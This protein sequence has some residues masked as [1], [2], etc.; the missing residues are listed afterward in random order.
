MKKLRPSSIV[1]IIVSFIAVWLVVD[2]IWLADWRAQRAEDR[3]TLNAPTTQSTARG[4]SI[5]ADFTVLRNKNFSETMLARGF[6]Q[7][8]EETE[9][10]SEASGKI[11]EINFVEGTRVK[12]GT[13]LVKINDKDLQAQ[14]ERAIHRQKLAEDKEARQK[15]LLEKDAISLE[16]YET[17]LTELNS[18]K[19]EIERTEI[20]APFDGTVGLRSVSVGEYISPQIAVAKLVNNNPIKMH[21]SISEKYYD[22]VKVNMKV[23]FTVYGDTRIHEA[24]VYAIDPSIDDASRM[25]QMRALTANPDGA[26]FPGPSCNIQFPLNS[27]N[28]AIMVPSEALISEASGHKAF[29]YKNGVA[30]YRDLEI[31]TRTESQVQVTKG[32]RPGD[33]LIVSGILQLRPGGLVKLENEIK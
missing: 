13:L 11:T 8:D 14:H 6:L 12:A 15:V 20:R 26:L 19:A 9:L 1:I 10:R 16:E 5:A 7:S 29:V 28:N 18:L 31:G 2:R 27:I 17:A 24:T 33:T 3:R 21:F 25:I 4:G 23:K 32:L 22:I 30:E